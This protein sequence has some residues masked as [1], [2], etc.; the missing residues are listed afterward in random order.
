MWLAISA[1]GIGGV[2]WLAFGS[3]MLQVREIQ[4][5]GATHVDA[6]DIE[7]VANVR[8]EN[9]LTLSTSEVVR[10][11][12]TLP[13][14][15]TARVERR[16]PGTLRVRIEERRPAMILSLGAARWTLD[17][18]GRV[19]SSGVEGKDLPVLAGIATGD[20]VAGG[21][22]DTPEASDALAAWRGLPTSLKRQ[23]V[24]IF[25]PTVERLTISLEDGTLVRYG[26]AE[27]LDAKN[28]VLRSLLAQLDAEGREASYI[29]VR[30]P[31]NPAVSALAPAAAAAS[32]TTSSATDPTQP[33]TTSTR[34]STTTQT[35]PSDESSPD[36]SATP[37]E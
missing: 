28:E 14:V 9:L 21:S 2:I 35:A 16:L 17:A 36:D 25:A 27:A 4:V 12:Q 11:V 6:A 15:K 31:T 34:T 20:V 1:A 13:W 33:T 10:R 32:A 8:G 5:T 26:A 30:V 18:R 24:G 37:G 3:S 19:L 7:G 22:I 29:D 23:V